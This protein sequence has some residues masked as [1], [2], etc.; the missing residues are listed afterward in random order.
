MDVR[1]KQAIQNASQSP[2]REVPQSPIKEPL[3]PP[4]EERSGGMKRRSTL[5]TGFRRSSNAA[6]I[7]ME[8]RGSSSGF[9]LFR[10]RLSREEHQKQRES[11][12]TVDTVN[13]NVF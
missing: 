13:T 3:K 12:D 5:V 9:T 11:I 6:A 7:A 1:I 8:R 10:N 2:A 4:T